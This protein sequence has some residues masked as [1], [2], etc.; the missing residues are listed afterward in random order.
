MELPHGSANARPSGPVRHRPRHGG[1]CVVG[2]RRAELPRDSRQLR[3]EEERLDTVAALR[4]GVGEVQEHARVAL[5]RSA[6]VAQQHE[7]AAAH[8]RRPPPELHHVAAGAD[9]VGDRPSKI[10]SRAASSNPSPCPAF[11]RAPDETRQDGGRFGGFG[12]RERGEILVGEAA[13]VAPGLQSAW[14]RRRVVVRRVAPQRLADVVAREVVL[15]HDHGRPRLARLRC[16]SRLSPVVL[17]PEGGEGDVEE[18]NLFVAMD[19][20]RAARVIDLAAFAEVHVPERIDD[21]E[22]ATAMDVD[23]RAPQEA[24]EDQQVIEETGHRRGVSRPR[25]HFA[26]WRDRAAPSRRGPRSDS[27]SSFAFST[28]PSVSSIASASSVSR[29][30]ATSAFTQSMV[31]DTPGFLY[32]SAARSSCTSAVTCSVSCAGASGD[33]LANDGQFLLERRVLDPLIE[34]PALQRVVH[35]TR[36][37]GREDDQRRLGCPQR[38]ELGNRDLEFGEQLE[39]ESFEL[40]VGAIDLVDQEDGRTRAQRVDR[41]KQRP[42]D[43]K[44]LAV[45]LP[46]RALPTERAGRVEDAQLEQLARVVPLVQRVTDVEAFI[47]LKTNQIGAQRGG[48]RRGQRRLADAGLALEEQRP[49]QSEREKQRHG[50]ARSAT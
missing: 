9:A 46:T 35:L 19:E 32:R 3:G 47:A 21:I 25:S 17:A 48:G 11:T 16:M 43:E 6:D 24:A 13:E 31:S 42:F 1:E 34:A 18:R 8:A 14:R 15:E 23:A 33:V 7:R 29:S 37:I 38:A 36:A 5:H 12:A 2:P 45:E 27:R 40:L 20:Q 22:Q 26:R 41:L 49:F 4:H 28:T 50:K 39:E 44:G 10:D 30:S